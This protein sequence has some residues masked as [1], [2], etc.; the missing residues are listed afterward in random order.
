MPTED[1]VVTGARLVQPRE[2]VRNDW[3]RCTVAD[4]RRTLAECRAR[5]GLAAPGAKGRAE[6]LTGDAVL[7]AWQGDRAGA[8]ATLDRAIGVEPT[9]DALVNRALLR[10]EAGDDAGALAD[11]DRA[12]RRSPRDARGYHYRGIV[13]ARLGKPERAASDAR[14]AAALGKTR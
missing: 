5:F 2:P 12:V 4:P 9:A 3:T 14:R 6:A 11:L 1:M 8:L 7:R 13:Q 10:M